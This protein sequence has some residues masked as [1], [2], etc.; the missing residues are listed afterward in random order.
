MKYSVEQDSETGKWCVY[1]SEKGSK[2][3][4]W[5]SR[6]EAIQEMGRLSREE[7]TNDKDAKSEKS[8]SK[9]KQKE[10]GEE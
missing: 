9:K 3:S 1:D 2:L 6:R 7:G 8:E 5:G 4:E 10:E